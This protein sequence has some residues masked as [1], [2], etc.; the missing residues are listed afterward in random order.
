MASSKGVDAMAHLD[1]DQEQLDA[2][3][4]RRSFTLRHSLADHPL[5]SAEAVQDLADRLPAAWVRRESGT[6]PYESR[7]YVDVGRGKPSQTI[8]TISDINTR[9]SLREIQQDAIYAP[10][11]RACQDEIEPRVGT[12]EGG[13]CGW[14]GYVFVTSPDSTT[15]MHLDP[16]HSFLLQIRG[17]KRIFVAGLCDP[18]LLAEQVA[19][20]V[21]GRECDF[22]ALRAASQEFVLEPGDGVYF[23]SFVP[24]WVYT[25][26][27]ET[28]VSF[29]LPFYTRLGDRA[30]YVH[31]FNTRLRAL[32]R[33][34]RP[35]GV[36]PT[37]DKVKA[38]TLR[39]WTGLRG[40][41]KLPLPSA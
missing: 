40:T 30:A 35:P 6:L 39:S 33:S 8:R 24:H 13:L 18:D 26:G 15:P 28:S 17:T 1:I 34:P 3:F 14:S 36:S 20:C 23:P 31:R 37:V 27:D 21:D 19:N 32:G 22:D 38:F 11:V 9:V 16:E 25:T 10:F 29:S 12:R 4:G 7:G 2:C 5:L 41:T